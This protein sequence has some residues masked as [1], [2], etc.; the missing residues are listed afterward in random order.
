MRLFL[1][2]WPTE[3][4][5]GQMLMATSELRAALADARGVPPQDWH[6]TLAFLGSVADAAVE[7][8]ASAAR[9]VALRTRVG[10]PLEVCLDHAEFWRRAQLVCAAARRAAPGAATLAATLRDTLV[11]SG[12]APD[13]KPFRAHVT[14]AR[15]V[16]RAP[17]VLA[18]SA[19]TWRFDEFSLVESRTTPSGSLYSV[20]DS[21]QLDS[22]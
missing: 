17:P 16:R 6:L 10:V 5:R 11:A 1:A 14:L 15:K 3:A 4:M 8:V 18:L 19:V 9:G 7:S 21:W 22:G 2:L 20:L 12:F 13:L